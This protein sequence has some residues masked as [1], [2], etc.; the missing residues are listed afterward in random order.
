MPKIF[1][2]EDMKLGWFIGD[3]EPHVM[4]SS[5]FEVAVKKYTK[6]EIERK[7]HH[8]IATE[9]TLIVEG[10][11]IMCEEVLSAGSIIKLE[12]GESTSFEALTNAITVVVKT[13]SVPF[14]KYE[15][16]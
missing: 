11:V 4:K 1:D 14:D 7:H 16:D 6:G 10:S 13:P 9:I 5:V 2:L 15:N 3:F 12:P 8:K